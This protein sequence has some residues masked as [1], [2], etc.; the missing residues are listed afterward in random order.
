MERMEKPL[1]SFIMPAYNAEKYIEQAVKSLQSQTVR[2]WELIVI[3]DCSSDSTPD[4]VKEMMAHDGRIRLM[5]TREPS[6]SAIYPRRVGIAEAKGDLI[7]PLDADDFVD[8]NYLENLLEKMKETGADAVYPVMYGS[9]SEYSEPISCVDSNLLQQA[10]AGRD[11]VKHTL[12]GWSIHCNGGLVK[13]SLYEE[14]YSEIPLEMKHVNADEL[15]TRHLLYLADKVAVADEKYY[16]RMHEGQNDKSRGSRQFGYLITDS[17]LIKF[18]EERFG[19]ESE[20]YAKAQLQAFYGLFNAWERLG[21]GALSREAKEYGRARIN[22]VRQLLDMTVLEA[23]GNKKYLAMYKMPSLLRMA[24]LKLVAIKRNM[25]MPVKRAKRR[26]ASGLKNI[27]TQSGILMDTVGIYLGRDSK[28]EKD[29]KLA[30]D[31]YSDSD[32]TEVKGG[33][34]KGCVVVF[35]GNMYHGGLTDRLRGVLS[36]YEIAR[37]KGMPFYLMWDNPFKIEDY[38]EPAGFDWRI[39]R[40]ELLRNRKQTKMVVVD[41]LNRF[42]SRVRLHSALR[43][44]FEQ[45]HLYTNSDSGLGHYRELYN[46]LFT[47][48]PILRK[49][50]DYHRL[51]L[52]D[53]YWSVSFRFLG[54]LGDFNDWVP[55]RLTESQRKELI[56]RGKNGIKWVLNQLPEGFKLLLASDSPRFLQEAGGIDERIYVVPGVVT[57]IDLDGE[58]GKAG[59]LKTFVD[60]QLIMGAERVYRMMNE[61]T[62]P[63]G[64]PRFAAEVSGAEFVD[65]EF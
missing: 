56:E 46:E 7:A 20:E 61:K 51:A 27:Y 23:S 48:A 21:K 64:F 50:I 35:D 43:G 58:S 36:A 45:I 65:M 16:Y 24:M 15:L 30:G 19:R 22:D 4:I 9:A 31:L 8:A 42:Q 53:R 26:M 1:A 25:P 41:D 55:E 60:Q 12:N 3:D 34:K 59:W 33:I 28:M 17:E 38:L 49:E 10:V 52:G 13:K 32:L 54:R 57:H 14:A 18:T 37:K 39:G 44:D 62:Y 40:T 11:C 29:M 5:A 2:D 6:G 63:T 47:P